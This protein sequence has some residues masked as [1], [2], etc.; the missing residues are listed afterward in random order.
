MEAMMRIICA[1]KVKPL[2]YLFIILFPPLKQCVIRI[3]FS[4][5]G[6]RSND[7]KEAYY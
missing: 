7:K 2:L 6:I 1:N 3:Q 4:N 5:Q